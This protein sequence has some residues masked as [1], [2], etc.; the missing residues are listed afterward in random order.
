MSNDCA[1][2]MNPLLKGLHTCGKNSE[3]ISDLSAMYRHALGHDLGGE[4]YKTL[5]QFL[6][7][8][9]DERER[10]LRLFGF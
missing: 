9:K 10:I 5:S 6:N 1:Q 8:Q 3:T 7:L 2:C 4:K